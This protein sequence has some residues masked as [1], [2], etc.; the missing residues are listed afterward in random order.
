MVLSIV[1]F[2]FLANTGPELEVRGIFRVPGDDVREVANSTEKFARSGYQ[3][4]NGGSG[5]YNEQLSPGE[6]DFD[7]LY[8][9]VWRIFFTP[10]PPVARRIQGELEHLGLVPGEYSSA[11]VRALYAIDFRPLGSIKRW[12]RNG[13]NCA[14]GLRPGKPIFFA[15]DSSIASDMAVAYG[16][17]RSLAIVVHKS[18]P[19]PPLHLDKPDGNTTRLPS[20]FYDTFIDLYLLALGGC[21]FH[22]KGEF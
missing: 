22:N 14:S 18:S 5:W 21:V 12:T 10:S 9:E 11:H 8:H 1:L 19:N 6:T 16:R 4:F 2:W 13:L 7:Q 17:N 3:S 20:D 15:S